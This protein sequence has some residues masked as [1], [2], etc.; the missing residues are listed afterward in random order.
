MF[1]LCSGDFCFIQ[2]AACRKGGAV[3]S[4]A[5]NSVTAVSALCVVG[6]LLSNSP[7]VSDGYSLDFGAETDRGRDAGTVSCG[8]DQVCDGKLEALG[9]T[10]RVEVSRG[11]S[12]YARV[13]LDGD[14]LDCCYFEGPASS[15]VV[16]PDK[17]SQA[18]LY[19]GIGPKGALFIENKR[20]GGFH[21][22]F[23]FR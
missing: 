2:V 8:F 9:L 23:N 7:A 11:R 17:P 1:T 18:P 4:F 6:T 16:D 22:R 12:L 3:R 5:R 21:L 14:N 15:I 19:K 10:V 13:R 20:V